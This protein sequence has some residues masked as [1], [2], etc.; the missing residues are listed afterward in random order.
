MQT[1]IVANATVL[2]QKALG[3]ALWVSSESGIGV[4]LSG[5]DRRGPPASE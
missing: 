2:V 4:G 3:N 1:L 5:L